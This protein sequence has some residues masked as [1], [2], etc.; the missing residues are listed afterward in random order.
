MNKI[1]Q[2]E[3]IKLIKSGE[4]LPDNLSVGGSLDLKG[5]GITELPDNLSV[6]GSL[7]LK[8]TGITELPDNL[9]VGGGLYLRGTGITDVLYIDKIG[10]NNRPAYILKNQGVTKISCGCFF[11]T[12][13]QAL[14]YIAY[15]NN[16]SDEEL[17]AAFKKFNQK[18]KG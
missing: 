9:S 13:H 12:E 14:K 8:G 6:G 4:K 10:G 18:F 11:G 15:K 2:S 17:K 3:F 16:Y 7:D 5:T 1:T